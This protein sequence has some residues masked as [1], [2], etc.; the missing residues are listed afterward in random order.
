MRHNLFYS[1]FNRQ[2][3]C[4]ADKRTIKWII[5]NPGIGKENYFRCENQLTHQIKMRL[6]I[7]DNNTGGVKIQ[8]I[9]HL[10]VKLCPRYTMMYHHKSGCMINKQ[11]KTIPS[12]LGHLSKPCVNPNKG[13]KDYQRKKKKE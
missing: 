11:V 9:R 8:A 10:V 12:L 3:F 6:M 4:I 5:P 7:T 13:R 1:L 2:I